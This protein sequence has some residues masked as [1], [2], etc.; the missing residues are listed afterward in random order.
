VCYRYQIPEDWPYQEARRLFKEPNVT[1]D[2]PEL[3]WT[4]PDEEVH[5]PT[6][7]A[8]LQTLFVHHECKSL[9]LTSFQGL[10]SFLVKDNGF[11]E[12]RVTKV[13]TFLLVLRVQFFHH[14]SHLWFSCAGHREDQICQE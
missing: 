1:L 5:A 10:I 13:C 2:I 9:L 14:F 8:Y 11:N 7:L 12:D 4:A 3:K 6:L